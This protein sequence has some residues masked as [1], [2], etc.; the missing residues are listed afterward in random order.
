MSLISGKVEKAKVPTQP[1]TSGQESE[2]GDLE[3]RGVEVE[4]PTQPVIS[5]QESGV[6]D[7]EE[8]GVR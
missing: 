8:R 6:G 1:V 4:V 7:L 2:A 5:G 3:E